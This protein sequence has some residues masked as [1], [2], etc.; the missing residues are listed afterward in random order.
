MNGGR[1]RPAVPVKPTRQYKFE[2]FK[3]VKVLGKGSFGKVSG[4]IIK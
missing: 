2:D 3:F 1:S 4:Y